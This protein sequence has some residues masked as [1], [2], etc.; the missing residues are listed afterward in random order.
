M[1][2]VYLKM[3]KLGMRNDPLYGRI[4]G[5]YRN[6]W[7]LNQRLL[8]SA[9]AIAN[10][11]AKRNAPIVFLKGLSMLT[12]VYSNLGARFTGDADLFSIPEHA[13]EIVQTMRALG[14]RY[15][16]PWMP[17][18]NNPSVAMYQVTKSTDF[19][20]DRNVPIDMHWN[21]FGLYHH[22]NP[23]DIFLLRK[24]ISTLAF[25]REYWKDAVP[26]ADASIPAKRLSNE[27][28]LIHVMVHGAEG[29]VRKA[30]RWVTDAAAIIETFPI[31]W[32]RMLERAKRFGL[33][34]ELAVGFR[35]LN[36]R[37]H[38]AIPDA[39]LDKLYAIP[40]TKRQR[41]EF[42]RRGNL[43]G[44]ERFS[45]A[46][47]LLMFWYAYW[48]YEPRGRFPKTPFGYLWY[49]ATC[50]GVRRPK[51]FG[52]ILGKYWKKLVRSIAA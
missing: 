51:M 3:E 24:N 23:W 26:L 2:L 17:D 44:G 12:D 14:W 7:V 47:N 33:H 32:S 18:I 30:L 48:V 29:S 4:K 25:T 11:C 46:N 42:K 1:P 27:D 45:P 36:E 21:I 37:M 28:M 10:E 35:Y 15:S 13:P 50:L 49:T 22:A 6:A 40:Y 34:L 16:K 52:Y 38:V 9:K 19:V 31:D 41:R 5:I 43:T 20:N 39:F 8:A